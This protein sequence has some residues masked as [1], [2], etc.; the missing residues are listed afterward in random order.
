M[1]LAFLIAMF[2]ELL[3]VAAIALTFALFVPYI[4]SIQNNKTKPHIFSW[5]IWGLGTLTVFFA[6]LAGGGGFG[7]WAIGFSGI[8]TAYIALLAYQK[9]GDASITRIDWL[10]F[11][12]A[13][14]AL[15]C[16]FLTSNPLWAVMTLTIVDLFG[17]GP[18]IRKAYYFP[19]Q[20]RISFFALAAARNLLVVLALEH[21]SFTTVLFPT[22]VG[23]ACLFLAI[24]ITYRRYL[25]AKESSH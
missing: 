14:L 22:A 7:A 24:L 12:L 17:F 16:W 20:E 25:Q 4:R 1:S 3:S 23:L 18:T 9:R 15:P 11:V 21:Y 5:V 6:Q 8:L 19:K 13:L 2:K 10:F